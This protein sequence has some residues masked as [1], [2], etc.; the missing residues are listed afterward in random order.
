MSNGGA[1]VQGAIL[2]PFLEAL[3]QYHWHLSR[4][5]IFPCDPAHICR[6]YTD[7]VDDTQIY[8]RSFFALS[9]AAEVNSVEDIQTK[10]KQTGICTL[11]RLYPMLNFVGDIVQ[12]YPMLDSVGNIQT[13]T[14]KHVSVQA[15][16]H[17]QLCE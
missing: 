7:I 1:P 6:G 5:L 8:V 2:R 9:N 11:Y 3:D 14:V 12:A 4:H 15:V 17:A 13:T 10:K 16:S